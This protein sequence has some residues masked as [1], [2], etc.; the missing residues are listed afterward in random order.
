VSCKSPLTNEQLV[1][2]WAN[3]LDAEAAA[4]IEDHLFACDSC[5]ASAE[6]VA[7]IAQAFRGGLPPVI[8]R[9]ELEV[10]R[11]KGL[12]IVE[13][14][15]VASQR[16]QVAFEPGVD[17]LIHRLGGL[18]LVDAERVEVTVRTESG[19]DVIFE[20]MF[21]PFDRER[22]EVLIACQRHF[23]SYPPDVVFDVRV[24]RA[25]QPPVLATYII[26]HVFAP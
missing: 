24:H 21:A 17:L 23:S 15:F 4:A 12:A 26:P 19:S 7:Q 5:F 14:S 9:T 2:Y 16:Q 25:A 8:S 1:A 3:D 6:R 18:D 22:G 11:A 10:L 20:E 13:N